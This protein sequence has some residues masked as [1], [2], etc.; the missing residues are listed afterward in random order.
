MAYN[1]NSAKVLAKKESKR[2]AIME[3]VI[4]TVAEKG[5]HKTNISEI[6]KAAGVA[7]GTVYLYYKSKDEMFIKAFEELARNKLAAIRELLKTEKTAL[8]KLNSFFNHHI[9]VITETPY[10]ARFI[11]VEIRQSPQ[12][13]KKFPDYQPFQE[14]IGYIQELIEAAKAEGSIADVDSQAV[15][16]I[17]FGTMDYILAEWSIRNHNFPLSQI[18]DRITTVLKFGLFKREGEYKD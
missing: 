12:F 13:Y 8:A 5:F 17:I 10:I 4:K 1:K 3:A 16:Y 9:D 6:A 18:K 15:S 14:Y 2:Q 11:G 7:D